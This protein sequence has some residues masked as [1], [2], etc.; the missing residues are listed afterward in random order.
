MSFSPAPLVVFVAAGAIAVGKINDG[1][2]FPEKPIFV[3]PVPLSMTTTG[4]DVAP[5]CTGDR[6]N[7]IPSSSSSSSS[8][9]F[10]NQQERESDDLL[11][12]QQE[13]ESD[14]LLKNQQESESDDFYKNQ[15]ERESEREQ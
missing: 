13:R 6:P 12:N 9:F 14:D 3:N 11:K 5:A 10:K 15:Q 4:L 8:F 7:S 2:I 1:S